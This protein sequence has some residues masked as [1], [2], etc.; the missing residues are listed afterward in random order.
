MDSDN[1]EVKLTFLHPHGPARSYKYP[2]TPDILTVTVSEI[3]TKV[4][5]RTATGHVYTLTKQENDL[6][7]KKL[8]SSNTLITQCL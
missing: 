5:P 4:Y 8:N 1:S 6:A 2:A 7:A 3:V